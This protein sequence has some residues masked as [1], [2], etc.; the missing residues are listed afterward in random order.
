MTSHERRLLKWP[1]ETKAKQPQPSDL[2]PSEPV[3][4]PG[5]RQGE[6]HVTTTGEVTLG[7][8]GRDA[9]EWNPRCEPVG[10]A[11]CVDVA[12][13]LP[14][15][16]EVQRIAYHHFSMDGRW[17][18]HD[19]PMNFEL[20]R[21]ELGAVNVTLDAVVVRT[22]VKHWLLHASA[23]GPPARVLEV[24]QD[25]VGFGPALPQSSNAVALL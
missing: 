14:R 12:S 17:R 11:S 7:P 13:F 5:A 8:A 22:R 21:I 15:S 4:L 25:V 1:M 6:L 2:R 9:T 19:A 20:G 23:N 18:A 3:P 10:A 16:A 24:T